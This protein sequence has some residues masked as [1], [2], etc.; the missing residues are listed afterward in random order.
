MMLMHELKQIVEESS[1]S[2]RPGA[3]KPD[4]NNIPLILCGDLNS[5]PNS[6]VVEYLSTGRISAD[7]A[8]FKELGY[9]DSLKKFGCCNS[10][11]DNKTEYVHPF[12]IAR[13]YSDDIMP[14]TNYS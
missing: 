12:K 2:F 1:H 4:A 6:G 14:Y 9:K 5:L 3:S 13:A 8:D 10:T 7:H 11:S